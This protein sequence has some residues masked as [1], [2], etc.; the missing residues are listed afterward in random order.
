MTGTTR[1]RLLLVAPEA[2]RGRLRPLTPDAAWDVVE[3]ATLEQARF[4]HEA[5]HCDV[6]VVDGGLAAAG[7]GDG[8]AGLAAQLHAPLVLVTEPRPEFLLE[9]QRHHA[10][11]LPGDV[12]VQHPPV[13]HGV[14]T[15]ALAAGHERR[16][17]HLTRDALRTSQAR[18]DRLLGLLWETVPGDGPARWLSQRHMLERLEE[19]VART[20][21][22]G[23][24]LAVVLGELRLEE[25]ARLDPVQVQ[26]LGSWVSQR[27]TEHKRRSD[28]AGQYGLGGFMLLLPRASAAEAIGTCT[29]LGEHLRHPG[30]EPLP[31]LHACFGLASVPD[32]VPSVP[33]LLRRAEERLAAA[34][35][36][37]AA[38][39]P[40]EMLE[41]QR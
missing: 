34:L 19:E 40:S 3:A 30:H 37:T 23:G 39:R 15:Q 9:S 14:L 10:L 36:M 25:G 11:W 24:P 7:W 33:S 32:D 4:I 21:R 12:A 22:H 1:H 20:R 8:L 41:E 13:F 27:I 2:A 5:H 38:R 6:A 16:Q 17:A 28:V 35:P 31:P 29:R 26:Q 18:V